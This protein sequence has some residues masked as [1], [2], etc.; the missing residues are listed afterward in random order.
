ME[1]L[2]SLSIP[3]ILNINEIALKSAERRKKE[4]DNARK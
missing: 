3:E 1:Y 4:I 2:E